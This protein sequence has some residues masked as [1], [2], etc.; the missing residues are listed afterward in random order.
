MLGLTLSSSPPFLLLLQVCVSGTHGQPRGFEPHT[1]HFGFFEPSS[2]ALWSS[3][4]GPR[5]STSLLTE[6]GTGGIAGSPLPPPPWSHSSVGSSSSRT[7]RGVRA[8]LLSRQGARG[9]GEGQR[10]GGRP[11]LGLLHTPPSEPSSSSS[12][13]STRHE[14]MPGACSTPAPRSPGGRRKKRTG[15]GPVASTMMTGAPA[16]FS[17]PSHLPPPSLSAAQPSS[18]GHRRG[19]C[20]QHEHV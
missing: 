15:R 4:R 11:F 2:R 16:I 5:A 3:G 7:H 19:G 10:R 17:S 1:P 8:P 6:T 12:S 14:L 18:G 13:S 9:K 20:P